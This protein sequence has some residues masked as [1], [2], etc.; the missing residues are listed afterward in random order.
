MA[1][2][3]LACLTLAATFYGLPPRAL[4]SIHAVEGGKVGTVHRNTDGSD[5][6]GPMQ[7]NTLWIGAL[8]R[9]TGFGPAEVHERLRT[10]NCFSATAAAAI[11]HT[12]LVETRGDL[13]LA[14]G[15]YHS[16][17]P[18]L[19]QRYQ[20]KVVTAATRLFGDRKAPVQPIER[21]PTLVVATS[22]QKP[23]PTPSEVRAPRK[24]TI[25]PT[26]AWSR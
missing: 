6:L 25:A 15:H 10:S 23:V 20:M 21:S 7:V 16:H 5:D 1:T 17:T 11:L 9:H 12:Y 18:L 4:A 8:A 24:A 14:I 3:L 22:G 2:S 19:N 13:M 26:S